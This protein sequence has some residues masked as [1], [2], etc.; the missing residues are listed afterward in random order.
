VRDEVFSSS[1]LNN[2]GE[3]NMKTLN[4][5]QNK[6][7]TGGLCSI[8]SNPLADYICKSLENIGILPN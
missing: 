5:K 1:H 3:T 4:T 6:S 7:V 2:K 8:P